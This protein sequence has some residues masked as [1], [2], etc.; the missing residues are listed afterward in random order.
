LAEL[1]GDETH[2]FAESHDDDLA[3]VTMAMF[4][5]KHLGYGSSRLRRIGMVGKFLATA[6]RSVQQ[7]MES[8]CQAASD[9]AGRLEL[10]PSVCTPLV[11]AFERWDGKGVP[12]RV[13]R[14]ELAP[15]IRF[16]HLADN[17]EAFHHTGGVDAALEVATTRRGTHFDPELVDL[18]CERAETI[19][20]GLGTFQ[21]W[22][23]VIDL[24][25]RLG[26]QM[27]TTQLDTALDALGDFA[28]L[29]S[30]F[31]LG[32]SRGVA[33]L[34]ADA[35]S[36][37]GLSD[38]DVANVRR[39]AAIHDVGMIGV[40]SGVWDA[41]EPWTLAQSERARTHPYLAERMFARVP[42]LQPIVA[43]AAQ[44]HERL[45]GTG[46]PHSLTGSA[47]S[48]TARLLAAADVYHALREARPHRPARDADAAAGTMHEE[49]REGRLDGAAVDAVLR[50]AGH[51]SA[52]RAALPGGLTRR[53]AEVLVLV[54]RGLSN[55]EIA[56]ELTISR[57]TVSSH[58][59][60][61]YT[62]LGVSTRTEAA[63]FAMQRGLVP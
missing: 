4:I 38:D 51:R 32:H 7:V 46:Y 61:I 36:T 29:K 56:S 47:L 15:A 40:P 10:G 3:G 14:S 62:K 23:Q 21:A 30:P 8:H 27:T 16:V 1:F 54:A 33:D 25:P 34:A 37:M 35:G 45:D 59:E 43:C 12:G 50:A 9:L 18:F 55:P 63:L 22:D 49:V 57:K 42:S 26:E 52:R 39:A 6:G 19:L 53:E 20:D 2:L 24:D 5:A 60:H 48:P 44:H 13:G 28:D 58:L 17:I 11:Q 41:T 31:R